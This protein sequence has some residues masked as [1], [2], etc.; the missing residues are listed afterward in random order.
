VEDR[1]PI[2]EIRHVSYRVVNSGVTRAELQLV[3]PRVF[4]GIDVYNSSD[5]S[6]TLTVAAPN[7]ATVSLR[8][9]AGELRRFERAGKF[10]LPESRSKRQTLARSISTISHSTST[11]AVL[12]TPSFQ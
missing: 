12:K 9:E 2:G 10:L 5:S 3:G 7:S 1:T 11:K 4:G 6:V 8:L